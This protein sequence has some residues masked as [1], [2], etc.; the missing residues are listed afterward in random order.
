MKFLEL[1]QH[2]LTKNVNEP[3]TLP[4][5][6]IILRFPLGTLFLTST[7][8]LKEQPPTH[9]HFSD[10]KRLHVITTSVK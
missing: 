3:L 8:H 7:L 2:S 1:G 4:S 5:P 10:V 6:F 9:A